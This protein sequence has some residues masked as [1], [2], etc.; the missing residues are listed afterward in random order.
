MKP[1]KIPT[2]LDHIV[3]PEDIRLTHIDS[4]EAPF[5]RSNVDIQKILQE[6]IKKKL[7]LKESKG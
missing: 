2:T 3:F 4:E 7:E 1:K 6:S 5:R